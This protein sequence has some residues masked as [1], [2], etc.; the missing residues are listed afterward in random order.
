MNIK[1]LLITACTCGILLC[2]CSDD[3][4][5]YGAPANIKVFGIGGRTDLNP[6][7][8]LGLFVD[9][10]VNADN[11]SM[12]VTDRGFAV[13]DND[14]RWGYDQSR[15]S[16][17]FVYAPYDATYKGQDFV[18]VTIPEDQST[19]EKMLKGNIMTAMTSADPS[20]LG[21]TMS[22]THAMTAMTLQFDNRTGSKIKK[23]TVQ[24]VMT[25]GRLNFVTGTLV[26]TSG[27]Q[28]ITP[29]RSPVDDNIFSFIYL[30]QDVTPVINVT[31]ATGK[32]MSF[33]FDSYCH[34]YP[35]SILRMEIELNENTPAYSILAMNGVTLTQWTSSG[36]PDFPESTP[37]IDLAG[38]KDVEPDKNDNGFFSAYLNKV[39]VTAVDNNTPELL[40]VVLE[41]SSKAIHVWC[42]DYIKL[43]VGNTISGPILGLMNKPSAD[44][45]HISHFYTDYATVGKNGV[46]PLTEGRFDALADNIGKWEYRRMLFKNVS[47]TEQFRNGRALFEQNGTE[48]QVMCQDADVILAEG[49]TGDLIGFPIRSGSDIYIRVYDKSAF[50]TFGKSDSDIPLTRAQELGLYDLS[51]PDT[52]VYSMPGAD[53]QYSVRVYQDGRTMQI[54]DMQRGESHLFFVRT[55]EFPVTGHEYDVRHVLQ[56]GQSPNT[57][58]EM[59]MECVKVDGNRAWLIDR[60]SDSGLVLAL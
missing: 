56:F 55:N 4:P 6:N 49:A 33:T 3:K 23:V 28:V 42:H 5:K 38:L 41:D 34:T 19:V 11:V 13:P 29:L 25:V 7:V 1:C 43:E 60:L 36:A 21:V 54:T 15:A 26:A 32:Q 44:E 2:G 8:R 37:Y 18:A 57:G 51:S 46:L 45:F 35:G 9:S 30:P 59:R 40:G 39:T 50:S 27:K 58:S 12:T 10:P 17:F 16:R 20:T 14:I 31:L 24:G 53:I 48:I 47:L 52:A 22:L